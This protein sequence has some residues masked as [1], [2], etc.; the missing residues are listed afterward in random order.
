MKMI[1]V[2]MMIQEIGRVPVEIKAEVI[3]MKKTMI[4]VLE[5]VL[6]QEE[7]LEA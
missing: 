5:A 1:S 4:T 6:I 2:I 7:V 3:V